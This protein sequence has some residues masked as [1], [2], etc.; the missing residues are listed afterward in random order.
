MTM[1]AVRMASHG[2]LEVLHY[3]DYPI[4]EPRPNE[5]LVRVLAT[6][7][8]RWDIKYRVGGSKFSL[9]GRKPFPLPMQPGRDAVGVVE[10]VGSEVKAFQSGDRVVGLVHPANPL[11]EM[12]IRGMSNLSSDID[13][14]GH[15]MFGGNAQ[16]VVRPESYWLPLPVGVEP[17]DA[18][19]A[20]WS[21]ATS[22]RILNDRLTARAG[23]SVLVVGGS[24]GMG[25]ATL[26]LA[27][28]MN[29]Q[30]IAVTRSASKVEFLK[31]Q[32][33]ARVFVLPMSNLSESVRAAGG[34]LGVDAA[35]DYSG[36]P[37]M[38]RLGIDVLRPGGSLVVVAGEGSSDR[39][40]LTAGDCVRLE[41]NIR[42]SRASTLDDQRIVLELL[43]Q[44]RIRPAIHAVMPM[45]EV[46][47]AQE[48]LESGAV[49]GRIVLN[50]WE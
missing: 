35:I 34:R 18:A 20:M 26:D 39:L 1:K 19:A 5:V 48:L 47:A 40:P 50:P 30:I 29:L 16:Y 32:G 42:G 6:T 3:G 33:A 10:A 17:A 37:D 7:V 22:L 25:S 12:T 31:A 43:A 28:A 11:S 13:Y 44:R 15:T 45:S 46:R 24:G 4:P 36:D 8:S 2:G 14:P 49:T 41:L 38:V 9:P 21:Y 23:D 27:R